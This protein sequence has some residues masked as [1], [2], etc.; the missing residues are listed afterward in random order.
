MGENTTGNKTSF[1]D[2]LEM[3]FI[4]FKPLIDKTKSSQSMQTGLTIASVVVYIIPIIFY[5]ATKNIFIAL[6]P[7][8][9]TVWI[10]KRICDDFTKSKFPPE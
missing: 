6:V 5:I 4:P 2:I 1:K 10:I 8:I 9:I 3:L 7:W